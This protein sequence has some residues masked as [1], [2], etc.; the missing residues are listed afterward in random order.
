MLRRFDRALEVFGVL[1]LGA[2]L[3]TVLAG[4]VTRAA[5]QP[6]EWTDEGARFLMVWLASTG[7]MIAGRR[8]AHVRIRFFQNKLP[9]RAYRMVERA[10]QAAMLLLGI[11]I[12]WF[13]IAL[14]RRN[15]ELEATSL[16]ISM[17]W[18][19][20][21]MVPAGLVMAAQAV[22][23]LAAPGRPG[24]DAAELVE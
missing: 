13:A 4:V 15:A 12:A 3:V 16:P 5:N 14:V 20:I 1:L 11:S 17:A 9:E 19:Y 21:P 23:Q 6:L 8:R 24:S 10:I 18:L 2:L 22:A 7:W